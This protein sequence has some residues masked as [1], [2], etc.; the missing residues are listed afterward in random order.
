MGRFG[1][2]RSKVWTYAGANTFTSGRMDDLAA[3]PTVKSLRRLADALKDVTAPGE[4][5]LDIL[6]DRA[7]RFLRRSG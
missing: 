2:N 3:H 1:R 4:I 5:V 7:R 6:R